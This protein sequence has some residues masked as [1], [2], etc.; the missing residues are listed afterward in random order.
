MPVYIM[1]HLATEIMNKSIG[2]EKE[3]NAWTPLTKN[4]MLKKQI[5]A[6]NKKVPLM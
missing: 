5:N 2:L 4:I 6:W 1:P 3:I